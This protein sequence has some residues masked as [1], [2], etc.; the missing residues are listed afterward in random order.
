MRA[1]FC[2]DKRVIFTVNQPGSQRPQ[3]S[4]PTRPP[5]R[6]ARTNSAQM[7]APLIAGVCSGLSVHLGKPVALIRFLMVLLGLFMGAGAILYLWLWMTVPVDSLRRAD[8]GRVGTKLQQVTPKSRQQI[9]SGQLLIGGIGSLLAAATI[10]V[11]QHWFGSQLPLLLSVGLVVFGLVLA[12]TQVPNISSWRDPKV[13]AFIGAGLAMVVAGL[14]LFLGRNDPAAAVLRGALIGAVVLLGV[15][16]ALVPLWLGMVNDLSQSKIRAAKETERA[17][18]AAH[19]H[20]S[21]LQTLTLIRVNADDATQVRTLALQQERQLRAWLYTGKDKRSES[22]AQELKEEIVEVESRYGVPI[23]IVIVGDTKPDPVKLALVAAAKEASTNAVRHGKPPVS[24][25]MEVRESG[26]EIYVKDAGAGFDPD[27]IAE[28]RHGVKDS[29]IGRMERV[30]GQARI[31]RPGA[32][33][34]EVELTLP[35]QVQPQSEGRKMNEK[36]KK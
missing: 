11:V 29:I 21:V 31:R 1:R 3:P 19:L 10:I 30:G 18:I 7:P 4:P 5:L 15:A 25:Y 34:T 23:E 28:D 14:V 27:D 33:G 2:H 22:L 9:R 35:T 13:L 6:R 8:D 12:W 32:G 17:D 26:I 36:R 20:D 16:V 24:V